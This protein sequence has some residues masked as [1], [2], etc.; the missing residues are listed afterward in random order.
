MMKKRLIS[1]ILCF[2][3]LVGGLVGC[4]GSEANNMETETSTEDI[5]EEKDEIGAETSTENGAHQEDEIGTEESTQDTEN[6]PEEIAPEDVLYSITPSELCSTVLDDFFTNWFKLM[7][8]YA[9]G[10]ISIEPDLAT[11]YFKALEQDALLGVAPEFSCVA[12]SANIGDLDN[13]FKDTSAI[14][15]LTSGIKSSQV[16]YGVSVNCINANFAE[17]KYYKDT[18]AQLALVVNVTFTLDGKSETDNFAVSLCVSENNPEKWYIN[19][20]SATLGQD[21]T[22]PS[23]NSISKLLNVTL[24]NEDEKRELYS[25]LSDD[26]KT[27]CQLF[28]QEITINGYIG[29]PIYYAYSSNLET[30]YVTYHD[31][32][33]KEYYLLRYSIWKG[34]VNYDREDYLAYYKYENGIYACESGNLENS[35]NCM[36]DGYYLY[37]E[38]YYK[39]RSLDADKDSELFSEWMMYTKKIDC[40][41]LSSTLSDYRLDMIDVIPKTEQEYQEFIKKYGE[42]TSEVNFMTGEGCYSSILEAMLNGYNWWQS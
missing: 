35:M 39:Y 6:K 38:M 23:A 30:L 14:V 21:D 8:S 32:E 34:K 12:S 33:N 31:E 26:Q 1:L 24:S 3:M 27:R 42:C 17:F 29:E 4:G 41:D 15:Y 25:S 37:E 13:G 5:S 36:T 19:R 9:F 10:N 11:N 22:K 2:G 28:E 16:Q 18:V 7:I 40:D 20:F